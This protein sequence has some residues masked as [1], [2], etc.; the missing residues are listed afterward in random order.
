MLSV[1]IIGLG[2]MGRTHARHYR[3]VADCQVTHVYDSDPAKVTEFVGLY[4]GQPT[5]SAAELMDAVNAVDICTP[6]PSHHAL[7]MEALERNLPV[8]CEKPMCAT[9]EQCHE[10]A[11]EVERRGTVFMPAHVVR[12]F[13]EFARAHKYVAE[14]GIGIPAAVRTRRGGAFPKW[15][16]GWFGD[17]EQSGGVIGDLII[18]DFDWLRW[19]FGE[20]DRVFARGL[21]YRGIPEMDYALVTL[22]FASGAVGHVEG[23][24]ADP[25]GFRTTFEASGD[26]GMVEHDSRRVHPLL[27][28]RA[29]ATTE[30]ESPFLSDDDPYRLELEHFVN[31]VQQG[32]QTDITARDGLEAVRISHAAMESL[33]TGEPVSLGAGR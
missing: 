10:I 23:S 11:L 5:G 6:T 30:R 7:I 26:A 17:F 19:T 4:G 21:L 12:F 22:K 1:G 9:P 15:S 3:N 16:A 18:H 32:K 24:W 14:G 28:S 31:C 29:G 20:V 8:L 27:V 13:P 33:K 25:G 2:N